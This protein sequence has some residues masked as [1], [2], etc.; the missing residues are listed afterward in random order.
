MIE[1]G[2]GLGWRRAIVLASPL[3]LLASMYVVFG[4]LVERFG[5][6]LGFSLAMVAYMIGWC[7]LLPTILL[8]RRGVL[9]L[10]RETTPK[11]GN[12]PRLTLLLILWPIPFPLLFIFLP[13]IGEA[14]FS[15]VLVSVAVGLAIGISEELLWRGTFVRLFPQSL[16]LGYLYPAV[17]FALWHLAPQSVHEVGFPGA[18]YSFI[19]YALALGL[20]YGYY[21]FRTGSIRWCTVSHAIHDSLGLAGFTFIALVQ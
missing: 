19:L 10:F 3:V 11:L 15:I 13:R 14:T 6:S 1:N 2:T 12:R 21:A 4:V 17:W 5:Y 7:L 16:A 20:S 18:P 9:D 8:G